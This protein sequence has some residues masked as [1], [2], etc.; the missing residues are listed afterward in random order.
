MQCIGRGCFFY[1]AFRSSNARSGGA[2]ILTPSHSLHISP[3]ACCKCK[4]CVTF[5]VGRFYLTLHLSIPTSRTLPLHTPTPYVFARKYKSYI[6]C[7]RFLLFILCTRHEDIRK[8]RE[9]VS[10]LRNR[11][12]SVKCRNPFTPTPHPRFSGS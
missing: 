9:N 2:D 8:I 3:L 7:S 12:K 11:G 1:S 6:L 4:Y 10:L 5:C